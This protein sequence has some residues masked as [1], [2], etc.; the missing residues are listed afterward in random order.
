MV[1]FFQK[2]IVLDQAFALLN[3]ASF[4]SQYDFVQI[5]IYDS[6]LVRSNYC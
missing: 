2:F 5:S 6:K 1:I 4:T 3:L